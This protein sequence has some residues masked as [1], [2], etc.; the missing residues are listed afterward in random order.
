MPEINTLFVDTAEM[1]AADVKL[2]TTGLA[3]KTV[4]VTEELAEDEALVIR[5]PVLT[6]AD[7]LDAPAEEPS[8]NLDMVLLAETVAAA[9]ILASAA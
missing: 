4:P 1:L 2:A 8:I 6:M 3:L 7:T 9:E 5:G